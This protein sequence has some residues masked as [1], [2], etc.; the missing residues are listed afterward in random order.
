[1]T[2]PGIFRP[3]PALRLGA[4]VLKYSGLRVG[5]RRGETAGPP[6]V[7]GAVYGDDVSMLPEL[8]KVPPLLAVLMVPLK[9]PKVLAQAAVPAVLVPPAA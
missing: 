4:P 3:S 5:A 1:M 9:V 6:S 8:P 7:R 2:V